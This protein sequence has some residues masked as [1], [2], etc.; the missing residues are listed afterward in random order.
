MKAS[1]QA[2]K[3]IKFMFKALFCST[4]INKSSLQSVDVKISENLPTLKNPE[5]MALPKYEMSFPVLIVQ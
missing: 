5:K 3:I 4:S 1:F 2:F